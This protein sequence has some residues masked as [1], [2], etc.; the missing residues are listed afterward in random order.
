MTTGSTRPGWRHWRRRPRAWV[1]CT[2]WRRR[3]RTRVAATASPRTP[4]WWWSPATPAGPPS[5][6]RPPTASA[7]PR[8]RGEPDPPAVEC[9]VAPTPLP[10]SFREDGGKLYYDGN[11]HGR[12]RTSGCDVDVCFNGQ[13]AVSRINLFD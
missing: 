7:S 6:A 10:V 11:Y 12:R 3:R 13:I 4:R 2:S 9:R 8:G 5:T 1:S